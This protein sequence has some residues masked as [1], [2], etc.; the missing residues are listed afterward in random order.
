VVVFRC[1]WV[2]VCVCTRVRH[3]K[4][5]HITINV[6][7]DT[8]KT[9]TT[10]HT[11]ISHQLVVVLGFEHEMSNLLGFVLH[12]PLQVLLHRRRVVLDD[13]RVIVAAGHISRWLI[14]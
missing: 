7:H 14:E 12:R 13:D 5:R 1:G 9:A 6:Q 11:N 10:M 2:V 4:K 8:T 3:K